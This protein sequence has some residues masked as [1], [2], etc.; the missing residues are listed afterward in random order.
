MTVEAS[1]LAD[2][3]RQLEEQTRLAENHLGKE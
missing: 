2:L 1:D 3:A